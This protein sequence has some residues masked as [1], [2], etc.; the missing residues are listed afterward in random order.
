MNMFVVIYDW[1]ELPGEAQQECYYGFFD[2]ADDAKKMY[3]KLRHGRERCYQSAKV[4]QVLECIAD[5]EE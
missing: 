4:C 2:S 3:D 5:K 1:S